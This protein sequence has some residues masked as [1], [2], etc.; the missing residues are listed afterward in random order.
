LDV[1]VIAILAIICGAD[2]FTEMKEFGK[3]KASFLELPNSIC[4]LPSGE[5]RQYC[6]DGERQVTFELPQD[7]SIKKIIGQK[8][9]QYRFA[10]LI[11][12][13]ILVSPS[14]PKLV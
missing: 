7:T 14:I 9:N 6:Q 2:E 13:K 3:T 4:L 10:S 12:F 8:P 1:I 11:K 5:F